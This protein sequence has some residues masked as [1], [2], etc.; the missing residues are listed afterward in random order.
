MTVCTIFSFTDDLPQVVENG[1]YVRPVVGDSLSIGVVK[2]TEPNGPAIA[3][4]SHSHG[5]EATLQ[6]AGGCRILLSAE[7]GDE[8]VGTEMNP[9]TV[10]IMPAEQ[11]HYGINT[12]GGGTSHRLN[13]VTPP[14]RE[15]GEKGKETAYYPVD[16]EKK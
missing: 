13:V 15:Y 12:F 14:R 1:L 10:V 7:V 2:F 9:G 5:E 3:A 11:P 4:K 8:S 6:L 16:G